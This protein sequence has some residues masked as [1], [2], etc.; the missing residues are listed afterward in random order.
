MSSKLK[1]LKVALSVFILYHLLTILILPNSDSILSRKLSFLVTPYANV[2]G[3]N[4]T[5]RF[6]SPEP[7]PTI[8]FVYDAD[9]AEGGEVEPENNFWRERGFVT[10]QWPPDHVDGMLTENVRRLVYHSRFT[11]LSRER[12]EK[13]MGSLLCRFYPKAQL[14]SVRAVVQE[15]PSIERSLINNE[16]FSKNT[17]ERDIESFEFSCVKPQVQP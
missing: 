16:E 10:G 6:F 12:V 14:V 11:T 5:W 4:T 8:H 7:S 1:V 3:I 17:A 9:M 15:I 13:F 2:V